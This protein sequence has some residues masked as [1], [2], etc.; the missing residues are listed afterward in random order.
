MGPTDVDPIYVAE[1]ADGASLLATIIHESSQPKKGRKAGKSASTKKNQNSLAAQA[2]LQK[3]QAELRQ[4]F[5][6]KQ[7]A[8]VQTQNHSTA[9]QHLNQFVQ[10]PRQ[11]SPSS[12][13][14]VQKLATIGGGQPS[15]RRQVF[16]SQPQQIFYTQQTPS[17]SNETGQ[18]YYTPESPVSHNETPSNIYALQTPITTTDAL[19]TS[20]TQAPPASP[21]ETLPSYS[22]QTSPASANYTFQLPA[23]SYTQSSTVSTNDEAH[24]DPPSLPIQQATDAV[25]A[26]TLSPAKSFHMQQLQEP[27]EGTQQVQQTV[28]GEEMDESQMPVSLSNRIAALRRVS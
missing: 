4:V 24:V 7:A 16:V 19:P 28:Q 2:E 18:I 8:Q 23:T 3:Q 13:H 22:I 12:F 1:G 26:L 15:P 5:L 21:N 11:S 27:L 25:Y 10:S 20:S 6:A 17:S 14:V 9:S